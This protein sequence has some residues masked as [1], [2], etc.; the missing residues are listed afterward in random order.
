MALAVPRR[1]GA[2]F[3][4]TGLAAITGSARMYVGAHL[5]WD[6]A[7]GFAMGVLAGPPARR[8]GR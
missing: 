6:V 4:A 3:A 1:R 8:W 7:G 2:R 5:P